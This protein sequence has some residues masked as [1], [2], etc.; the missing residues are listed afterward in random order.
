MG[1][2][3]PAGATHLLAGGTQHPP[4]RLHPHSHHQIDSPGA[5]VRE[6]FIS[7][8]T[9]AGDIHKA[10][11]LPPSLHSP[12]LHSTSLHS[13]YTPST[14]GSTTLVYIGLH[15][16]R[17]HHHCTPR[18]SSSKVPGMERG[19]GGMGRRR[20]GEEEEEEEGVGGREEGGGGR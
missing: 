7:R 12:S 14:V 2:H 18:V 15:Y 16:R 3:P 10:V 9:T 6:M 19:F 5:G 13:H 20:R 11:T 17:R 8:R 1:E 4:S